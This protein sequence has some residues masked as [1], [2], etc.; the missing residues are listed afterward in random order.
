MKSHPIYQDEWFKSRD[1]GRAV[2]V[3]A[4]TM[5]GPS[6]KQMADAQRVFTTGEKWANFTICATVKWSTDLKAN[7]QNTKLF[8]VF[9]NI[10]YLLFYI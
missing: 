1:N 3:T 9:W 8:F 10:S 4:A 6:V 2:P 5:S 7:T